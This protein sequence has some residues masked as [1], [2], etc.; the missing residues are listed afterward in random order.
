MRGTIRLMI[1]RLPWAISLLA[2][3]WLTASPV[4]LAPSRAAEQGPAAPVLMGWPSPARV[5]LSEEIASATTALGP[6]AILA[7]TVTPSIA[8]TEIDS[9]SPGEN[10][11]AQP[12][13]R[14]GLHR[15]TNTNG[16][17]RS[18]VA[19]DLSPIPA[20]AQ[21]HTARLEIYLLPGDRDSRSMTV[22]AHRITQNWEEAKATWNNA[23]AAFAEAYGRD[24]IPARVNPGWRSL[25]VTALV[26]AWVDGTSQNYGILLRG[27]E[28]PPENY[29]RFATREGDPAEFAP[30]LVIDWALPNTPPELTVPDQVLEVNGS[31]EI[32]LWDYASDAEDEKQDLTFRIANTPYYKAGV[33]ID[34]HILHIAPETSWY[35]FTTVEVEVQDSGGLSTTDS[36]QVTVLKPNFPPLLQPLPDQTLGI[37][38]T[39]PR[40]IDLW[41]YAFDDEDA[42]PDLAFSIF[43]IDPEDDGAGVTIADNQ[44]VAIHPRPNWYGLSIVTIQVADLG[45]LTTNGSFRVT[46]VR[47]YEPVWFRDLPAIHLPMNSRAEPAVDLWDHA[48][49]AETPV[50]QLIFTI[51]SVSDPGAGV[52]IDAHRWVNI[53]PERGWTGQAEAQIEVQD[54]DGLTASTTLVVTVA[55]DGAQVFLPVVHRGY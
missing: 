10:Y 24:T 18:L 49:D 13:M 16:I 30:R 29:R 20:N 47:S 43:S 45:G 25:E 23:S 37:G 17:L 9:L 6:A 27:A 3:A 15:P 36:F 40:A 44:Y 31:L 32:D 50:D 8:D 14:A 46:V 48:S 41:N 5:G 33:S 22:T 52:S 35:G 4:Q 53:V 51:R 19:F 42:S 21:I 11:G 34:G 12:T 39:R 7:T 38:T 55:Y 54:T 1:G 28:T 26:Q 2:L